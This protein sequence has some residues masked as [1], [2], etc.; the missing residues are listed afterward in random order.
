MDS[1]LTLKLNSQIIENAKKYAAEHKRSLSR[2]IETYLKTLTSSETEEGDEIEI[3]PFVKS[4]KTGVQVPP[5]LDYKSDY[6]N[7][8]NK[9][10]L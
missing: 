10:H 4:L 5:D 7:H 9:K 1:K 6:L 2:I 3:S 8:L